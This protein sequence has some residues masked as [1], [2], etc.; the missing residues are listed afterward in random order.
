VRRVLLLLAAVASV[1]GAQVV[2]AHA[3]QTRKKWPA[4]DDLPFAPSASTAPYVSLGYRQM[5]ADLL[6]I[7]A[8]GYV[9]SDNDKAAGTRAL[10]EAIVALDPKFERVYQFTGSALSAIG[11]EPTTD[12]LL[13]SIRILE[14][15]MQEFPKNC[16]IPLLAGQVYTVELETDDPEQK[17]RWELEGARLLERAI[18]LP[19]CPKDTGTFVAHLRS[20]LGQREKAVRDLRELIV[21]T[22]DAEQRKKLVEKLAELEEK[23]SAAL[24]YELEVE[25]KRFEAAWLAARPD[26][27]PSMYLLLGPPLAHSFRLEELAVDRDLVGTEEPIEPLPPVPD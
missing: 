7:R 13:A 6:W 23:D 10:V 12:D 19:G 4:S 25:K 15:G 21:Y 27:P 20:K 22:D 1:V 3:N 9:G 2:G 11:T 14:R 17:A 5:L 8:I 26:V 18:R 24:E 16:K